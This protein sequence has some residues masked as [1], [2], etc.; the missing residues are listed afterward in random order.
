MGTLPVNSLG[1]LLIEDFL[2]PV[3]Q[4]KRNRERRQ[5]LRKFMDIL[6]RTKDEW[7]RDD[8]V[9]FE[10]LATENDRLGKERLPLTYQALRMARSQVAQAT[11]ENSKDGK[12]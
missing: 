9:L 5:D 1:E 11:Y 8:Y 2:H 10:Q 6:L 12:Q 3:N 4:L 7:Q